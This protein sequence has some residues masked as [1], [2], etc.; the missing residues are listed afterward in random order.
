VAKDPAIP[1][2]SL[3][4]TD[5]KV[6]LTLIMAGDNLIA[7]V[8]DEDAKAQGRMRQQLAAVYIQELGNAIENYREHHSRRRF[9]VSSIYVLISTLVLIA[10]LYLLNRLYRAGDAKVQGWADSKKVSI[11]IQAVELVRADR[12]KTTLV[13]ASKIIRFAVFIILLYTYV[14]YGLSLFP[15]TRPFASHLLDYIL[16]PLSAM[17][18]GV[19]AQTPNLVIL[20]IIIVIT[21]YALKITRLFF[22]GIENGTISF[23]GF[24]PEWGQ[25]TYRIARILIIAF[26]AVIAFPYIPGSESPAFKGISIFLGVLFSLGSTSAISNVLAGYTITY[27]KPFKVGDRVKIADFTGDILYSSCQAQNA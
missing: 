13:W 10:L 20:T 25:P 14:H 4:A 12:I 1:I 11:H 7:A 17:A 27:R 3:T 6:P 19:W 26:A 9:L 18:R 15:Q 24:Y 8:L 2:T 21:Y 23:K 22:K 16:V 5:S